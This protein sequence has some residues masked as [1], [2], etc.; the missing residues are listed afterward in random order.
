MLDDSKDVMGRGKRR[1]QIGYTRAACVKDEFCDQRD[2]RQENSLC[3]YDCKTRLK[4]DQQD[5]R[6]CARAGVRT[7]KERH[8]VL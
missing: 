7:T 3:L 5:G 2:A 1:V 6:G 4:D 8:V